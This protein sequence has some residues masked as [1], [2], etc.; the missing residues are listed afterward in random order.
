[1]S[2]ADIIV[3]ILVV[4]AALMTFSASLAQFRANDALTRANLIGPLVGVAIPLLIL[5]KLIHEWS[6]TGFDWH[7]LIKALLTLAGVWIIGS[8]SSFYMGRSIYGVTVV[9]RT[10][11]DAD[12][13]GRPFREE[14]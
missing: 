14:P 1:M 13:E 6:A 4:A 12:F 5:A 11:E 10:P 7:N 2:I 9:D 3:A 8:V